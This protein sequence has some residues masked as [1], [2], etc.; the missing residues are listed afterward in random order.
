MEEGHSRQGQEFRNLEEPAYSGMIRKMGG[1]GVGR[2]R[3][4]V[5]YVETLAKQAKGLRL[6]IQG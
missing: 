2:R 3:H 6:G 4:Q 1:W 5:Q